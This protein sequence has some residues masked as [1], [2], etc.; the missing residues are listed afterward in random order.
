MFHAARMWSETLTV[1]GLKQEFRSWREN[2]STSSVS[3]KDID[4]MRCPE[5]FQHSFLC[6]TQKRYTTHRCGIEINTFWCAD[7]LGHTSQKRA[8]CKLWKIG[9][10]FY[11]CLSQ[12]PQW[13]QNACLIYIPSSF[14]KTQCTV[15]RR[16]MS[17]R[18]MFLVFASFASELELPETRR[19]SNYLTGAQL[20]FLLVNFTCW[21]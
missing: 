21:L 8:A 11:M 19:A 6:S 12:F 15:L 16:G 2:E 18:G 4:W 14:W 7:K 3:F 10:L 9:C 20:L 13:L 17:P 1:D 5:Y